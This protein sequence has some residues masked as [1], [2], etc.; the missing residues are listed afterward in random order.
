MSYED[1]L[2]RRLQQENTGVRSEAARKGHL[3]KMGIAG[4]LCVLCLGLFAFGVLDG[5]RGKEQMLRLQEQQH[6]GRPVD[7]RKSVEMLAV[8]SGPELAAVTVGAVSGV[9]FLFLLMRLRRFD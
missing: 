6:A 4:G 3:L 7:K 9:W 2:V 5:D 8:S 1:D